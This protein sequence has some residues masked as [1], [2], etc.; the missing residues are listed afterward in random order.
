MDIS[1]RISFF[2]LIYYKVQRFFHMRLL[3]H[4]NLLL[5]FLNNYLNLEKLELRNLVKNV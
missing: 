3:N 2:L 1:A 4:N 5:F